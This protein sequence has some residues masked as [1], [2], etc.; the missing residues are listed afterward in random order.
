[1][2]GKRALVATASAIALLAGSGAALA[3]THCGAHHAK[4]VHA[5]NQGTTTTTPATTTTSSSSSGQPCPLPDRLWS[6]TRRA[7]ALLAI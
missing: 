4:T 6:S 3:A 2:K 1:M 5:T 7:G